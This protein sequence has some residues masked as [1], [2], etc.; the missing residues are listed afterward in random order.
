MGL[1]LS[2]GVLI[3]VP[4]PQERAASGQVIEEAIQQALGEAR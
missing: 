3:A 1:G 4:C 2:S